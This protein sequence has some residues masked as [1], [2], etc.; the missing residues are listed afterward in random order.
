MISMVLI[1]IMERTRMVGL[2]KALGATNSLI[3]K[4]FFYQSLRLITVG[5]L[6]GNGI[7]L[8]GC[9]LQYYFSLIPLDVDNYYVDTVP[10]TFD[11]P[12]LAGLNIMIIFMVSLTLLIPLRVISTIQPVRSIR[13]D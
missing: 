7:G 2:L 3:R 6:I 8:G 13:F 9:A 5:L 12:T 4:I 1:L 10:V 11:W